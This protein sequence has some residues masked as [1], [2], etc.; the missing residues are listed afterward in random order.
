MILAMIVTL[1]VIAGPHRGRVIAFRS[2]DTFVVG[3]SSAAQF[4]LPFR[5]KTLSRLHFLVE[6]NPPACRL[7]DMASL[8]GTF[9]NG[10]RVSAVDLRDGDTIR[11][12]RT[13]IGV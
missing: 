10:R 7:M 13:A 4:R 1:T 6:V 3:R 12:G 9:V 11:G 2:H 8:N 5:D